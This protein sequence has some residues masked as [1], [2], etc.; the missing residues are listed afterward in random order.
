MVVWCH[1]HTRTDMMHAS[2]RVNQHI[3]KTENKRDAP[4]LTILVPVRIYCMIA[5]LVVLISIIDIL[6]KLCYVI[7][8]GNHLHT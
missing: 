7:L 6:F 2:V 5:R 8:E 4:K 3:V 1:T